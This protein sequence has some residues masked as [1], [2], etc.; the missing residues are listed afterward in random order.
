MDIWAIVVVFC[1]LLFALGWPTINQHID[2]ENTSKRSRGERT[3]IEVM[4]RLFPFHHHD[5]NARPDWLVNDWPGRKTPARR[6]ELDIFIAELK[7]AV[8]FNGR[9]H[10]MFVPYFHASNAAFLAQRLRDQRKVALCREKGID[11][12]VVPFDTPSIEAFLMEHPAV[13]SRLPASS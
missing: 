3:C 2:Q 7:L 9:Q 1:L 5:H 10:Y 11:L 8:E 6:L 4:K 12:I 13:Q